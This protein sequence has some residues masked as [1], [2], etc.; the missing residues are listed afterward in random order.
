M[1]GGDYDLVV[2]PG[3]WLPKNGV[4]QP[5]LVW[6]KGLHGR[7]ALPAFEQAGPNSSMKAIAIAIKA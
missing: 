2:A 7:P 1:N 3:S 6:E 5:R 4:I